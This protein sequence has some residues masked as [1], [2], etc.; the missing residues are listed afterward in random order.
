V[1]NLVFNLEKLKSIRDLTR[2][3]A[4]GPSRKRH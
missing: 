3:L 4:I 2:L 1:V